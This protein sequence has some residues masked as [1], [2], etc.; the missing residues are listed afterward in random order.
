MQKIR[1]LPFEQ[2]KRYGE[3]PRY[4]DPGNREGE[5]AINSS[6]LLCC[7]DLVVTADQIEKDYISSLIIFISHRWLRK[8]HPDDE[9]KS[10]YELCI[11][12]IERIIKELCQGIEKCFIWIDYSCIDQT[13]DPGGELE[14][15]GE[16]M[17]ICDIMF[18]PIVDDEWITR[19]W[20]NR[21]TDWYSQYISPY[22]VGGPDSYLNRGWCLLEMFYA[23][24]IPIIIDSVERE[25][26]FLKG[27]TF[28][29]RNQRRPHLIYG[30]IELIQGGSGPIIIP[31]L[32]NN[33]FRNYDPRLGA[34]TK[35][36]D[37]ERITNF[38]E[39]LQ[40]N[41]RE[42]KFNY[43]GDE[44]EQGLPH[45]WGKMIYPS[46][47]IYEG[48]W[49]DGQ[50]HGIG[51]YQFVNGDEYSGD[52]VFG[53]LEGQG[54]YVEAT[55]ALYDGE[56]KEDMMH[57]KGIYIYSDGNCYIGEFKHHLKDGKGV[58]VIRDTGD[59][60][61]GEWKDDVRHGKGKYIVHATS[62]VIYMEYHY[63]TLRCILRHKIYGLTELPHMQH[64]MTIELSR[65]MSR[66]IQASN[67][68]K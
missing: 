52:F 65:V 40:S 33:Y 41:I 56:W 35:E 23:A 10:K 45:G 60:Y 42:D 46:G 12:G 63:R 39:A 44:N 18:T 1:L 67:Q 64:M 61:Q 19:P 22:W 57:G 24:N 30:T 66:A 32:Q 25:G 8:N 21:I 59:V 26:N 13:N 62:E 9:K 7:R 37:R 28:H 2:L 20:A 6:E 38:L 50:K 58:A 5:F 43:D 47:E 68:I 4:P 51:K 54:K 48:S 16:I 14:H 34:C 55:G 15:L 29:R 17:K 36:E 53:K 11:R 3:I 49:I 27:I 31:S